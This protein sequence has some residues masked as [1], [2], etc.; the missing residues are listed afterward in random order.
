MSLV[1]ANNRIVVH[2]FTGCKYSMKENVINLVVSL[3]SHN[4]IP[5]AH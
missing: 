3:S 5:G 4:D 2:K 1:N